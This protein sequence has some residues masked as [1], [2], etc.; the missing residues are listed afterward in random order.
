MKLS[1]HKS[2]EAIPYYPKA[3]LYGSDE[4]WVRLS[5]NENPYPPSPVVMSRVLETI[6]HMNRYPGGEAELKGA[7]A[8]HY[9]LKSGE[10]LLGNG[11][12]EL[13]ELALKAMRHEEKRGVI[14]PE[15]S[16]PFYEIAARV[17]GFEVT[18]VPLTDMRV[19]LDR[20]GEAITGKTR[21]IFL[22][23][24]NNPTGTI[25]EKEPFLAFLEALPDDLLVVVDEAYGEFAV[26]RRFPRTTDSIREYP[27]LLLRT[28]SKAYGLAGLRVGYGIG[29]AGLLSFL[30]RT[31]QP[32][33]INMVALAAAGAALSDR[34]H[35]A[36][37]LE[38][39]EKGKETLYRGFEGLG[40]DYVPTEA[41]FVLTRVGPGAEALTR[42]LFEERIIVR[43][44]GAYGLPEYVRVT[45]GTGPEN[46][47]FLEALKRM[48]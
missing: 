18:K 31:R 38:N 43:W 8:E 44:M 6:T 4:G 22:T 45:V 32:F 25:Y 2:I 7:L 42:K 40:L 17:Y 48:V 28:F 10:V 37:V 27:I 29:E 16:F 20:I 47:R 1:V 21:V 36:K 5:S 13:I 23:N 11:S 34:G 39:N 19:D 9:G 12:N 35:L 33:S 3:S 14:M 41:N 24:P 30:E 26:N 15:P 46:N